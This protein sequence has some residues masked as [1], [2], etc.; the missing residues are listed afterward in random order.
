MIPNELQDYVFQW[1]DGKAGFKEITDKI[2]ALALNGASKCG[3]LGATSITRR[4]SG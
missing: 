1:S 2:M 4:T 3:T